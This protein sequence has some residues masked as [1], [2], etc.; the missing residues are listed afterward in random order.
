MSFVASL[1]DKIA[2]YVRAYLQEN[3]VLV[4]QLDPVDSLPLGEG[5]AAGDKDTS[6]V[7]VPACWGAVVKVGNKRAERMSLGL[8]SVYSNS[9]GWLVSSQP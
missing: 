9:S 5:R 4:H 2:I 6:H 8:P 3:L 7:R 1:V